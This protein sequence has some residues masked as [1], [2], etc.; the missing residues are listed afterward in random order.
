MDQSLGDGPNMTPPPLQMGD[1]LEPALAFPVP[2]CLKGFLLLLV[3]N[4]LFFVEAV[5]PFEWA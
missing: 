3:T 5:P 1:V 4:A 2:F